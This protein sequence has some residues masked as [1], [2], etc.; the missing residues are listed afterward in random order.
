[1]T[2]NYL[3]NAAKQLSKLDKPVQ[4]RIKEYMT[5]VSEL[6]D[7]RSRGKGLLSN[8]SGYWRYRVADFR[9]I[10]KIQDKELIILVVEIADRKEVY[11]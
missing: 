4:K 1:M 8:L 2:V 5:E 3:P 10:C 7:P 6:E 11:K 9:V